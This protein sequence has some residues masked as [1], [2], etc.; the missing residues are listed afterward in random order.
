MMSGEFVQEYADCCSEL[1]PA[2]APKDGTPST[3]RNLANKGLTFYCGSS[4]SSRVLKSVRNGALV[5]AA[6]GAFTGFVSGEIFGGEV[7]FGL[8]GVAGAGLGAFIQGTVGATNG[9]IKGFASAEACQ[10]LGA[11]PGS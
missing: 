2:I 9:V 6:R 11:Y 1:Y 4:P 7:T 3:T 8:S 5:G 10:A